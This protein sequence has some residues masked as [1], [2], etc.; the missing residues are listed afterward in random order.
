LEQLFDL[1]QWPSNTDQWNEHWGENFRFL[2]HELFL[3]VVGLLLR[4]QQFLMLKE[5]FETRFVLPGNDKPR[6][7]TAGSFNI[8]YE[9]SEVLAERNQRLELRRVDPQADLLKERST[10]KALPFHWIQ[11]A[12]LLCFVRCL[13][14]NADEWAWYPKTLLYA[15]WVSG[16]ETF[17]RA[18]SK[19]FY[20]RFSAVLGNLTPEEFRQK[21]TEAV[22]KSRVA[23]YGFGHVPG[24]WGK[25]LN[26]DK[27]GT[28]E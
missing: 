1:G 6:H 5:I 9:H 23:N 3:C 4:H 10:T 12:D 22:T 21:F 25:W 17:Q 15:R 11:Q 26:L 7:V 19:A 24:D 13:M 2:T 28:R 18:E 27:L 8:F 20:K 14:F 16:F